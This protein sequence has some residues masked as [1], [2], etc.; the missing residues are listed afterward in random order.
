MR[1]SGPLNPA[2]IGGKQRRQE[3]AEQH[4]ARAPTSSLRKAV[5]AT[6]PGLFHRDTAGKRKSWGDLWTEGDITP[7]LV[8][9]QDCMSV[10]RDAHARGR[11]R[12]LLQGGRAGMGVGQ[13]GDLGGRLPKSW[14][15]LAVTTVAALQRFNHLCISFVRYPTSRFYFIIKG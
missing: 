4:H 7:D 12:L 8:N 9:G 1:L 10:F 14:T 6:P 15:R 13:A 5:Q 2:A 3:Q 11:G